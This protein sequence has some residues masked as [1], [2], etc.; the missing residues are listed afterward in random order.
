MDPTSAS[1][2]ARNV[3]S[4]LLSNATFDFGQK[5][6]LC[7]RIREIIRNY[8]EGTSVLKELVQ[9]ADDAAARDFNLC[10]DYRQHPTSSV[11]NPSCTQL[12]GAALLAYN[13]SQFTDVDFASIQRIGDSLKREESKGT[14]TG[15]FGLGFNS[16]YHLTDVPSFVSG[17]KVVYFDPAG[18]HLPGINP[19]EPGKLFDWRQ[20]SHADLFSRYPD[21]FAPFKAFGCAPVA[22]G[23]AF[24]GTL[25]RL[26][27]RTVAQAASSRLS[28][29]A[30]PVDDVRSLLAEFSAEAES[31]LLFT[32]HVERIRVY[33]WREGDA[34]PLLM[35]E[36]RVGNVDG[37]MRQ[38]RGMAMAGGGAAGAGA[39]AAASA[40]DAPPQATDF[41]LEIESTSHSPFY[42]APSGSKDSGGGSISVVDQHA[43][44]GGGA[45]PTPAAS[46]AASG[47]SNAH[48]SRWLV[49]NQLGGGNT[50]QLANDPETR[51]L[52]LVPW[53]GVA[54]CVGHQAANKAPPA[55]QL[56]DPPPPG[57]AFCFLPLPIA[58]GLPVH[59]NGYFEISS[60]RRDLWFGDDMRGEGAARALWNR[61]MLTSVAAPCYARALQR[62]T[63]PEL[64]G[65]HPHAVARFLPSLPIASDTQANPW[66]LTCKAVY[67]ALKAMNAPVLWSRTAAALA[68]MAGLQVPRSGTSSASSAS[69]SD[70][71]WVTL[72]DAVLLHP[73]A[74]EED[75]A[76]PDNDNSLTSDA[77]T[78]GGEGSPV[79]LHRPS[80]ASLELAL[81]LDNLPVVASLPAHVSTA[82]VAYGAVRTEV[83]PAF[84]RAHLKPQPQPHQTTQPLM[85]S[86]LASHPCLSFRPIA[87]MLLRYCSGDLRD[88][89]SST[90]SDRHR[91]PLQHGFEQLIGL[92]LL[93]LAD[94]GLGMFCAVQPA[95]PDALLAV[96]PQI[97]TMGFPRSHAIQAI[98][99]ALE[100]ARAASSGSS[101]PTVS[102]VRDAAV[103]LLAEH[104][105][106]VDDEQPAYLGPPVLHRVFA[107]QLSVLVEAEQH[108]GPDLHLLL[109][110]PSLHK[111]VS[112]KQMTLE[113]VAAL[114]PALIPAPLRSVAARD[115][116][117]PIA[118]LLAPPSPPSSPSSAPA[119][120]L[121]P[122]W[123]SD[124]WGYLEDAA[125]APTQTTSQGA[126]SSGFNS[127]ALSSPPLALFHS[128]GVPLV[129]TAAPCSSVVVLSS[130]STCPVVFSGDLSPGVVAALQAIGIRVADLAALHSPT[131]ASGG[132]TA[133]PPP[134]RSRAALLSVLQPS[135]LSGLLH[136]LA[137]TASSRCPG[138][139]LGG[140]VSGQHSA[141]MSGGDV[142][143][144]AN[145]QSRTFMAA[146]QSMFAQP[147]VTLQHKLAVAAYICTTVGGGI[148][149]LTPSEVQLLRLLPI[150]PLHQAALDAHGFNPSSNGNRLT[151]LYQADADR[152]PLLLANDDATTSSSMGTLLAVMVHH[153]RFLATGAIAAEQVP[154]ADAEQRPFSSL[155]DRLVRA[156]YKAL[157]VQTLSLTD[158]YRHFLLPQPLLASLPDAVRTPALLTM[159]TSLP[160]LTRADPA[161]TSHLATTAFVPSRS[162]GRLCRPS[163]LYDAT[164]PLLSSL[165]DAD[166]FP[167]VAFTSVP[168][169]DAGQ[170][171]EGGDSEVLQALRSLGLATTMTRNAV[172][173]SARSVQSLCRL[174]PPP[175][176][177]S[178][179][180]KGAIT[181]SSSSSSSSSLLSGFRGLATGMASS[182]MSAAD[183][184]IA[185]A[186]AAAAQDSGAAAGPAAVRSKG[187]VT[188]DQHNDNE[189]G[190]TSDDEMQ[191]QHDLGID[192]V[193]LSSMD[194]DMVRARV[195]KGVV[196]ATQLL[197]YVD[198]HADTLFARVKTLPVQVESTGAPVSSLSAGVGPSQRHDKGVGE[199]GLLGRVSGFIKTV[200]TNIISAA[201]RER[202]RQREQDAHL[203]AQAAAAAARVDAAEAA[204]FAADLRRIAWIPVHAYRPHPAMPWP[205]LPTT[206]SDQDPFA[207]LRRIP[208][209]IAAEAAD[210]A[211]QRQ[212]IAVPPDDAWLCSGSQPPY[213]IVATSPEPLVQAVFFSQADIEADAASRR[214]AAPAGGDDSVNVGSALSEGLKDFLQFDA[215]RVDPMAA[216]AQ[217]AELCSSGAGLPTPLLS[218]IIPRLYRILNGAVSV[219]SH[220]SLANDD[221]STAAAA[222]LHGAAADAP[223]DV[224]DAL[225]A[226][227]HGKPWVCLGGASGGFVQPHVVAMSS[228]IDAAPFL[229]V[230]PRELSVPFG[231]FMTA[232][233][234][235]QS[236]GAS[237][238]AF[239]LRRIAEEAM[240]ATASSGAVVSTTSGAASPLSP[241]HLDLALSLVQRLSDC[242]PEAVQNL[243][244]L[245]P[246][247]A[248][249]MVPAG[250]LVFDD[251]PWLTE[252]G[253]DA[254]SAGGASDVSALAA[255]FR[256][257]HP[258]ISNKVAA[259]VGVTS[260]RHKLL[261]HSASLIRFEV[262]AVAFGQAESLTRRIRHILELYPEGPGIIS[263]FIQ[264]A[265]DAGASTVS[266]MLDCGSYGTSS[267]LSPKMAEW[268]GPALLIH[269]DA[270]FNERDFHNLA[271][272]GQASKMERLATTGRFGLGF[273][274]AY[275]FTDL[276]QL[277][278][279]DSLVMF[280]PHCTY[281]PGAH[282][283]QPGIRI[284]FA[285]GSS[286]GS[287]A[288]RRGLLSQFPDQFSPLCYFGCDMTNRYNGTL[289]RFPLRS[290]STSS[291]S[292]IKQSAITME[293]MVELVDAFRGTIAQSLLFLRCVRRIEVFV[294]APQAD[295]DVAAGPPVLLY[296]AEVE[297]RTTTTAPDGTVLA[298]RIAADVLG[299]TAAPTDIPEPI[300]SCTSTG[301][302][303][304]QAIPR[305]IGAEAGGTGS[306]GTGGG[307]ASAATAGTTSS[308]DVVSAT[309]S[310][311]EAF[312]SAL[313]STP[314]GSLPR[315][316][317]LL[318]VRRVDFSYPPPLT[319]AAIEATDGVVARTG[320]DGLADAV[321]AE[322]Q[323]ASSPAPIRVVAEVTTA[324]YLV[325]ARL[326][327]GRARA[328]A[329]DPNHRQ[330]K[331]IPWA[332]VAARLAVR[333]SSGEGASAHDAEA[334][335]ISAH[336]GQP[337]LLA[338]E[339]HDPEPGRAFCFL[340]LPVASGGLPAH[341]NG[342]FEL[343]SNRRDIWTGSDMAGKGKTRAVWNQVL[344]ADVVA[345]AYGRLLLEAARIM[346]EG[347]AT[348]TGD[349][350]TSP[351]P[352]A[353]APSTDRLA[354]YFG[355]WPSSVPPDP[356]TIVVTRLLDLIPSVPLLYTRASPAAVKAWA[357]RKGGVV[358]E[359]GGAIVAAASTAMVE[360]P[361]AAAK[362]PGCWIA[363]QAAVLMC[364]GDLALYQGHVQAA[365]QAMGGSLL[366][367]SGGASVDA[368]LSQLS[369]DD[370][371]DAMQRAGTRSRP[372][373]PSAGLGPSQPS[374]ISM[375]SFLTGAVASSAHRPGSAAASM[376]QPQARAAPGS[377]A[378]ALA[379]GAARGSSSINGLL[380]GMLQDT[381]STSAGGIAQA[382][383][384]AP[385]AQP[386]QAT[387]TIPTMQL[388][389]VT[390]APPAPPP[391]LVHALIH[392]GL[393]IAHVPPSLRNLMVAH[394]QGSGGGKA[395]PIEV[396]SAFLRSY[397]RLSDASV[398]SI[399]SLR[400]ARDGKGAHAAIVRTFPFLADAELATAALRYVLLDL[401]NAAHNAKTAAD[402]LSQHPYA[403]LH[404]L[405][406]LPLADGTLGI[407]VS[408][409]VLGDDSRSAKHMA[410]WSSRYAVMA[411][412]QRDAD[413]GAR[414]LLKHVPGRVLALSADDAITTALTSSGMTAD[415]NVTVLSPSTL[416]VL[417]HAALPLSWWGK[418]VMEWQP[419]A[420]DVSASSV[421]FDMAAG[422]SEPTASWVAALWQYLS[423]NG[424]PLQSIAST[425]S[426]A[427][428]TNAWPLLPVAGKLRPAGHAS[429]SASRFLLA[430]AAGL[431]V[432]S[433]ASLPQPV[434]DV[435]HSAGVY[436]LDSEAM[437]AT[438]TTTVTAARIHAELLA[439]PLPSSSNGQPPQQLQHQR[440]YVQPSS[441]PGVLQAI[442]NVV[443]QP[444]QSGLDEASDI[445]AQVTDRLSMLMEGVSAAGRDALRRFLADQLVEPRLE[446][447]SR[448]LFKAKAA[449]PSSAGGGVW[450][451]R[452]GEE[453]TPF[454]VTVMRCLPVHETFGNPAS[455]ATTSG[456][457]ISHRAITS[458]MRL[459][460][461]GVPHDLLLH[462][463]SSFLKLD[464]H[465]GDSDRLLARCLG[466]AQCSDA[467][468]YQHHAIPALPSLPVSM[469]D[470]TVHRMLTDAD[471]LDR[472]AASSAGMNLPAFVTWA[473]QQ[474]ERAAP[475][476]A[477]AGGGTA[478]PDDGI[479]A[480]DSPV[481]F[482]D[483]L[484]DAACIPTAA[485]GS[486]LAKPS[487]L[488]DPSVPELVSLMDAGAF[489][490]S[491]A[492]LGSAHIDASASNISFRRGDV[493]VI[494]RSLGMRTALTSTAI[495]DAASRVQEAGAAIVSLPA[496]HDV[497]DRAQR[498]HDLI[499]RA[500]NL[501][502]VVADRSTA[503]DADTLARLKDVAW[504]PVLQ[505]PPHPLLPWRSSSPAS[506]P[507]PSV[508]PPCK[509]RPVECMW[510]CSATFGLLDGRAEALPIA[511]RQA[512]GWCRSDE[513]GAAGQHDVPPAVI[514]AQ[515]VALGSL[516]SSTGRGNA[517]ST[518]STS[519]SALDPGTLSTLLVVVPPIYAALSDGLGFVRDHSTAARAVDGHR[520]E[521]VANDSHPD[522]ASNTPAGQQ[523]SSLEAR[524]LA[525]VTA[526][527]SAGGDADEPAALVTEKPEQPPLV[528]HVDR[529][530]LDAVSSLL[531]GRPWLFTGY[532]FVQ[533]DRV[534][535]HCPP[536]AQPYLHGVP[537]ELTSLGILPMLHALGLQPFFGVADL[538]KALRSLPK[539]VPLSMAQL[540]FAAAVV[541]LLG[542]PESEPDRRAVQVPGMASTPMVRGSAKWRSTVA[543]IGAIPVPDARGI[544]RPAGDLLVDDA[545]WLA[546]VV[547]RAQEGRL[548][549]PNLDADAVKTL[550]AGS[551]RQVVLTDQAS[552]QTLPCAGVDS[553]T[554]VLSRYP[555]ASHIASDVTE[556][557]DILG[558]SDVSIVWDARSHP[559]QSLVLPSLAPLQGPAVSIV[560]PNL[561]LSMDEVLMMMD[562]AQRMPPRAHAENGFASS[563]H[564]SLLAGPG[565]MSSFHVTDC[566]Q[567]LSGGRLFFFDPTSSFLAVGSTG[568]PLTVHPSTGFTRAAPTTQAAS[569]AG[570]SGAEGVCKCYTLAADGDQPASASRPAAKGATAPGTGGLATRFPDQVAPFLGLHPSMGLT[571]GTVIRLP[572]RAR[573]SQLSSLVLAIES[574]SAAVTSASASS[575]PRLPH[576]SIFDIRLAQKDVKEWLDQAGAS[577]SSQSHTR[578]SAAAVIPSTSMLSSHDLH[579]MVARSSEVAKRAPSSSSSNTTDSFA[580][581]VQAAATSVLSAC[582]AAVLA[583]PL[584]TL[585][586]DKASLVVISPSDSSAAPSSSS[587]DAVVLVASSEI[588]SKQEHRV[589]RQRLALDQEWR[590]SSF[591]SLFRSYNPP[592]L[593]MAWDVIVKGRCE[594]RVPRD[595]DGDNQ[596]PPA[597]GDGHGGGDARSSDGGSSLEARALAAV[598]AFQAN[599][600][601]IMPS[602]QSR[603]LIAA[604]G[605]GRPSSALTVPH[606]AAPPTSSSDGFDA[607]GY[608]I[609]PGKQKTTAASTAAPA[610]ASPPAPPKPSPTPAPTAQSHLVVSFDVSFTDRWVAVGVLGAGRTREL[611]RD[612][613]AMATIGVAPLV[614]M[615]TR[616]HRSWAA[617]TSTGRRV[618]TTV[619]GPTVLGAIA[620]NGVV[621][622]HRSSGTGLPVHV[623]GYF[624][625]DASSR[626]PLVSGLPAPPPYRQL[627]SS[628]SPATTIDPCLTYQAL[629]GGGEGIGEWNRLC[630]AT[631]MEECHPHVL[632]A[633]KG[634]LD[635]ST[636]SAEVRAP[637]I[638]NY[639][640]CKAPFAATPYASTYPPA[641]PSSLAALPVYQLVPGTAGISTAQLAGV[642]LSDGI[643]RS[644]SMHPSLMPFA[645]SNLSLALF[646]APASVVA[647]I[648]TSSIRPQP[649]VL[650]PSL[651]RERVQVYASRGGA[652][653]RD[654]DTASSLLAFLVSDTDASTIQTAV[655]QLIGLPLLPLRGGGLGIVGGPQARAGAM[656]T[657]NAT[658][659]TYLIA[660]A[661]QAMLL[662]ATSDRL[663][664]VS[665]QHQE[666]NES[667]GG[668]TAAGRPTT[669]HVS[670]FSDVAWLHGDDA[671]AAFSATAV[672][673][674]VYP[675]LSTILSSDDV[676][677][678][679]GCSRVTPHHIAAALPGM[680]P[681]AWRGAKVVAW[682]LQQQEASSHPSAV[683]MAAFLREVSFTEPEA[684]ALFGEW[685]MV[686][687][688]PSHAAA[689][690]AAPSPRLMSC[691]LAQHALV[692]WDGAVN[693][694]TERRIAAALAAVS[695]ASPSSLR[696]A[697]LPVPESAAASTAATFSSS[698]SSSQSPSAR[699]HS[700]L[701][702]CGA[703]LLDPTLLPP[704]SRPQPLPADRLAVSVLRAM[705]ATVESIN[706]AH[707]TNADR[708]SLLSL[709]HLHTRRYGSFSRPELTML[710]TLPLFETVTGTY[711]AINEG[712][713]F[714]LDSEATAGVVMPSEGTETSGTG[715]GSAAAGASAT[716]S[717]LSAASSIGS[718]PAVAAVIASAGLAD[719]VARARGTTAS[720]GAV[721]SATATA[722]SSAASHDHF[723]RPKQ[724]FA[725]LYDELGIK[726]LSEPQLLARYVLPRFGGLAQEQQQE[727][728]AGIRDRWDRL[729]G[730]KQLLAS[731]A[732]LAWVPTE[733]LSPSSSNQDAGLELVDD[734]GTG[735]SGPLARPSDLV[736][737]QH[738]LLRRVAL[739]CAAATNVSGTL[740]STAATLPLAAASTAAT[741]SS[742]RM[743]FP[744][745]S[746]AYT[747]AWMTMLVDL[748]L[749]V[750]VS[751]EL[752]VTAAGMLHDVALRNVHSR[753][754]PAVASCAY[755]LLRTTWHGEVS[756]AAAA[757]IQEAASAAS[758]SAAAS[759][760]GRGS[761]LAG[762]LLTSLPPGMADAAASLVRGMGN[763]LAGA[764]RAPAS[765]ATASGAQPPSVPRRRSLSSST[766]TASA[767]T[768]DGV[769]LH[770]LLQYI[771]TSGTMSAPAGT[772]ADGDPPEPDEEDGGGG[773]HAGSSAVTSAEP[774]ARIPKLQLPK[775]GPVLSTARLVASLAE[776]SCVPVT[777]PSLA[778]AV[779]TS[780]PDPTRPLTRGAQDDDS[781]E[782]E[783]SQPLLVR[784]SDCV[785]A[786]DAHLAWT[787]VPVLPAAL[788]PPSIVLVQA[789][790]GSAGGAGASAV[791][792]GNVTV[793][794]ALGL[795][796]TPPVPVV[797]RH[798]ENL[799]RGTLAAAA[800][801]SAAATIYSRP[802]DDWQHVDPPVVVFTSVFKWLDRHWSSLSAESQAALKRLPLIPS[803]A[804]LMHPSRVF[805]RLSEP[806][807]PLLAEVPR[808]FGAFDA[809]LSRLGVAEAPS[810][811]AL[812]LFLRSFASEAGSAVLNPNE[813]RAVVSC[814]RALTN[815]MGDAPAATSASL[816]R[817]LH[818]PVSTGRLLP[819]S[820]CVYPDVPWLAHRLQVH[821]MSRASSV[822]IVDAAITPSVCTKLGVPPLSSRVSEVLSPGARPRAVSDA[823]D[824]VAADFTNLL[825]D[826]RPFVTALAQLC[827]DA[828]T[829]SFSGDD[830]N[831]GT[832]SS[833]DQS[834]VVT[835]LQR[836]L[837]K[838]R[839]QVVDGITTR[840][841]LSGLGAEDDGEDDGD[842]G[843]RSQHDLH[844]AYFPLR[845]GDGGG[846]TLYLSPSTGVDIF[847]VAARAIAEI[848]AT[849]ASLASSSASDVRPLTVRHELLL[850]SLL[851]THLPSL[852]SLQS[853]LVA[854]HR[855]DADL[856]VDAAW[857]QATASLRVPPPGTSSTSTSSVTPGQRVI[858]SHAALLRIEPLHVFEV[859]EVVAVDVN[860]LPAAAAEDGSIAASPPASTLPQLLVYGVVEGVAAA[861]FGTMSMLR[862]RVATSTTATSTARVSTGF[863]ADGHRISTGTSA[864]VLDLRSSQVACFKPASSSKP[865]TRAT[866]DN[867]ISD[868]DGLSSI[869]PVSSTLPSAPA[870]SA[871][872]SAAIAAAPALVADESDA[873]AAVRDMLRRAGL[874]PLTSSQASTMTETLAL[875][876][877]VEEAR[878]READAVGEVEKLKSDL[879]AARGAFTCAICYARD[880]DC[881]LVPCGHT[882]CS[883]CARSLPQPRCP[884]DRQEVTGA[885]PFYKPR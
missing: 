624:L 130:R 268:Q 610:S 766:V 747:P 141:V 16:V 328:M 181:T 163:A 561:N 848:V 246:D 321:A 78:D 684:M 667:D 661:R 156:T 161:F 448:S 209:V 407:F 326:G 46:A 447:T 555:G 26:P 300:V 200:S 110:S 420:T 380:T 318:Q 453:V 86:L 272:I 12:A 685:P 236:F 212:S 531:A 81:A 187:A 201:D 718:V 776:L 642:P 843:S 593:C 123:L 509:V 573:P 146:L 868:I 713:A 869:G 554:A 574:T 172:L 311:K 494:L 210:I 154:P 468:F 113:D 673:A 551:L 583:A 871:T 102:G 585:C 516:Y 34:E 414:V 785:L 313:Q 725:A 488:Y 168:A 169:A 55:W 418:A 59:I 106:D 616:A 20:P 480:D 348:T 52:R 109:T 881:V 774:T 247:A 3:A 265:D 338:G 5:V 14:K 366:Q 208:L 155:D 121:G 98:R 752:V 438:V 297:G 491:A 753:V 408:R 726:Q 170:S 441:A 304:W 767:A 731:L 370:D 23:P 165:L 579:G 449:A 320:L 279:G 500:R 394:A 278:S 148:A 706:W 577:A 327:A 179:K 877:Q 484:R 324:T 230:L 149:V 757:Q 728:M 150:W 457:S 188:G 65:K 44:G 306:G 38:Q 873:V 876:R 258:K 746:Y 733:V 792:A 218:V 473:R 56:V 623:G 563:G 517:Q 342:Y 521:V 513:G 270:C 482:S 860:S 670:S 66:V 302:D 857:Q 298:S 650:T 70:G 173:Q 622:Q 572:L 832:A 24:E 548:V 292:E 679:L 758:A 708:D 275:H 410:E 472:A 620:S 789:G 301:G 193:D 884:F 633:I 702:R 811:Q 571:S 147:G 763:A 25:F 422:S 29:R 700:L 607:D 285:T 681:S 576:P 599:A 376:L 440:G 510:M 720:T 33:E 865:A 589:Q 799:C 50:H 716:L 775:S 101:R 722:S 711:T 859:G 67:A 32:K 303:R 617:T 18:S 854:S 357:V 310:S 740:A 846:I 9:N 107:T 196:R 337:E 382:Y 399:L 160:Y 129:P 371:S 768:T 374:S 114:L 492:D 823:A 682:A 525:A 695:A 133:V 827:S 714:L 487:S 91:Q 534:A 115:G 202:E 354:R 450:R 727:V 207:L 800:S 566:M 162:S 602:H 244:V 131:V 367:G 686:P 655:N 204:T 10:L 791:G 507:P 245:A 665:V 754:T 632:T 4:S 729:R 225:R 648:T 751:E 359:G 845:H 164:V 75:T 597:G 446:S 553:I 883:T 128:I 142:M 183:A 654:P 630:I 451:W 549:H 185:A 760:G 97:V 430:L 63:S 255:D 772:A 139:T 506:Q 736:H 637:A 58:T 769:P 835:T 143:A 436:T 836:I 221:V 190:G 556:V 502:R 603:S 45:K 413:A 274:S 739:V 122:T 849:P 89:T 364:D 847:T 254:A 76:A 872:T 592:R 276:P 36:T 692:V 429:A 228:P 431:P 866:R 522:G 530:V 174:P 855:Q 93:P 197:Q 635:R 260:L 581:S 358:G 1:G 477:A 299:R 90:A 558:C 57:L 691:A 442:V 533:L 220:Q 565:L 271:K 631:C 826:S 538:V 824:A 315:E 104:A 641:L 601:T 721:T 460:P 545:Q 614:T 61:A 709:F 84:L 6:D 861:P 875:R 560:L 542:A 535:L 356:W 858:E 626:S 627:P 35:H 118:R 205:A 191:M 227:L 479:D 386:Q 784:Y 467:Y 443:Q 524:A 355:L 862:V 680:L 584:F 644:P 72:A 15:R 677:S 485:A 138:M 47:T 495:V 336:A 674:P 214:Q 808:A 476:V 68:A 634:E 74:G 333:S 264:N 870:Q 166:L 475:A 546:P 609:K 295:K 329:I 252:E 425:S 838:A 628:A 8:P 222:V 833:V 280:D 559:A 206:S 241:T 466:V 596:T 180:S 710:K 850:S 266:V 795:P 486:G 796:S 305:F 471:R 331:L 540:T 105:I 362:E 307:G 31:M 92:P 135:T 140:V 317:H 316:N 529:A 388:N 377:L 820:S 136:A 660:T 863:D 48:R 37:R 689:D 21:Q 267:L 645:S 273:N 621:S 828:G 269:N 787:V 508:M 373:T 339:S 497:A 434:I 756:P 781:I 719:V 841:M 829:A 582:A 483:M 412:N 289:F 211:S 474:R 182:L 51:H 493:L 439:A 464:A 469:R 600:T 415:T 794:Q 95:L 403:Q 658:R 417:L 867:N 416:P 290:K 248:A 82:L 765:S 369:G 341:V 288:G 793:A 807:G 287:K 619:P 663:L 120:G 387:Y 184:A 177:S 699:L 325:H 322:L 461:T 229:H 87:L 652:L 537:P 543:R 428:A 62:L 100:E 64:L 831:N 779:Y 856:A 167:A 481:L 498:R 242:A 445:D 598:T 657:A 296:C 532:D 294:R 253:G 651:L 786:S 815:T 717:S 404:G 837:S 750:A 219:K 625:Q 588:A 591:S 353:I 96:V 314:Q 675:T 319:G 723:L 552:S 411:L 880:V 514:A 435:L 701:L 456:T 590:K 365:A 2:D 745:P 53:A 397:L 735:P 587:S 568:P 604:A 567:V 194:V 186:T 578:T 536:Y 672:A 203:R 737:P 511:A 286:A 250:Q 780:P 189:G 402:T 629:G 526:M 234:V 463:G 426:N 213:R 350:T 152:R 381:A 323:A 749:R 803:G 11:F 28:A 541:A 69:A 646:D 378:A 85:G 741:Q 117:V 400:L 505:A 281:V 797:M 504:M 465:G 124:V 668:A 144:M 851:R 771:A 159:L 111:I 864:P 748:G 659:N 433:K 782:T 112:I 217:L 804:C 256:F 544:M 688:L 41:L 523:A 499:E 334:A 539:E 732:D 608:P 27:L 395:T 73:Q 330:L 226:K 454:E 405:P 738:A 116:E 840:L 671:A 778:G 586:I 834:L 293:A 277:V 798:I 401:T 788:V 71:R 653:P 398:D 235:R 806:L 158:F 195:A 783:D 240:P 527:E 518:V 17:S 698:S 224:I 151:A 830:A 809:L 818:L 712:A 238:Y 309:G 108:L 669:S 424:V 470:S 503:M 594:L 134:P 696:T 178:N 94:G 812:L 676:A 261:T 345:P 640:P 690:S 198:Q 79:H 822:C 734:V 618:V 724:S 257:V 462:L 176:A 520:E 391:A 770:L 263:E 636:M 126:D 42:A 157:G 611:A 43:D 821:S 715:D 802:L 801:S 595:G 127:S 137:L 423:S 409:S 575:L 817:G 192:D 649:R 777:A 605:G 283:A 694:A 427:G 390:A 444:T 291:S 284:K 705:A 379:V 501:M 790:Q 60:N 879:E 455:S 351:Q 375:A 874:P 249:C 385:T 103:S 639:W 389:G 282:T 878:R 814:V 697:D 335:A 396:S 615:T 372:G 80:S 885:M 340:P 393:P 707:V 419:T 515:L 312:Y 550:G 564:R 528:H 49:C 638:F 512:F 39:S 730:N 77:G 825:A 308:S 262:P 656:S 762:A 882:M 352:C 216:A 175:P 683:W 232:M 13:S 678:A 664:G 805:T 693:P 478:S 421:A 437:L 489:P 243:E 703:P 819:A 743:L 383:A 761:G 852:S 40:A 764:L 99:V 666:Q 744:Y 22:G 612:S 7:V 704:A 344:L 406:L 844:A 361:D 54:V 570:T 384:A 773:A 88:S 83:S 606:H 519:T 839:V 145:L 643:F 132:G 347:T 19:A 215:A 223:V 392:H 251:A 580:R 562:P 755:Q 360:A 30:H 458:S 759:A 239:V 547:K 842:V 432:I 490:A 343:S 153:G 742:R 557:A 662:P 231:A 569:G 853:P 349:P 496:S 125:A 332:A 119:G 647:D 259:A 199:T 810:P 237:D 816:L 368:L 452:S 233:G 363:P 613:N 687:L 346:S 459:P 171:L 813:L